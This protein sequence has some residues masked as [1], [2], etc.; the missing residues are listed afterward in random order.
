MRQEERRRKILAVL[1]AA[2]KA[3]S[4]SELS[5]ETGVSRQIIVQ[6]I[7]ILR[8]EGYEILS[9]HDGYVVKVSKKNERVFKVRHQSSETED[10][11]SLIVRLGG[12]VEDVFVW[13]RVYGRI[14]AKLN[15]FSERQI[16]QFMQGIKS[17]KSRELMHIT[18]G[19]HYH[20]VRADS[21]STLDRIERALDERGYAVPEP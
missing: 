12:V 19:Y 4:G 5:K 9:T 14:E 21:E 11:L 18:E 1:L 6:D 17:G 2:D 20:T 13:H 15:I 3:V 8:A 16:E 7:G 10:E